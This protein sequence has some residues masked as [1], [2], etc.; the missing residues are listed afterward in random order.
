MYSGKSYRLSLKHP[1]RI[2]S[3]KVEV[4]KMSSEE[5]STSE[6]RGPVPQL[7]V[8][9]NKDQDSGDRSL[10][11]LEIPVPVNKKEC[12][13]PTL[14]VK[15]K[16]NTS[17]K[18][19]NKKKQK[20]TAS[21]CEPTNVQEIIVKLPRT[22]PDQI[23]TFRY[24]KLSKGLV[25]AGRVREINSSGLVISLPGRCQANV[26]I[27]K[28][29]TPYTKQLES[30]EDVAGLSDMFQ[31]GELVT[32][33]VETV[34][35]KNGK[36]NVSLSLNPCDANKTFKKSTLE[37]NVQL[38]GA[39]E[40]K[41]EHGYVIDVGIKNVSGFLPIKKVDPQALQGLVVGK[42]VR[43][44]VTHIKRLPSS[45]LI[46]TLSIKKD[47][48]YTALP[49][50][51]YSNTNFIPG[52]S[53]KIQVLEV[54]PEGLV[55]KP[56]KSNE[57]VTGHVNLNNL[58]NC[59]DTITRFKPS[60]VFYATL[61][62]TT[63]RDNKYFSL[64]PQIKN[65]NP[66]IIFHDGAL[67]KKAKVSSLAF[68]GTNFKLSSDEVNVRGVVPISRNGSKD[69]FEVG[70]MH[71]VRVMH[72]DFMEN[73]YI[74]SMKPDVLSIK[75]YTVN[76]LQVGQ[77]VEGKMIGEVAGKGVNLR[78][79]KVKVFVP[80]LHLTDFPNM[81]QKDNVLSP[82]CRMNN[83][84]EG[85][86]LCK[87]EDNI[88]VTLKPMLVNAAAL[89]NYF[90]VKVGDCYYGTVNS[91][92]DRGIVVDFYNHVTGFIPNDEI[93]PNILKRTFV[94]GQSIKCYVKEVD[95]VN[96]KLILTLK[97]SILN[98]G[99]YY[100]SRYLLTVIECNDKGFKVKVRDYE[101]IV[102]LVPFEHL[103]DHLSLIEPLKEYFKA[104]S[105]MKDAVA[106]SSNF[107][108]VPLFSLRKSVQAFFEIYGHDITTGNLHLHKDVI[109]PCSVTEINEDGIKVDVCIPNLRPHTILKKNIIGY[110]EHVLRS[111]SVDQSVL[112]FPSGD[113]GDLQLKL[114]KS[115]FYDTTEV[116]YGIDLFLDYFKLSN[117]LQSV[118]LGVRTEGTVLK[119]KKR[120][121]TV[122]LPSMNCEAIINKKFC[123]EN[124]KIGNFIDV[125]VLWQ[126]PVT[127]IVR[128]LPFE[129]TEL[130]PAHMKR[131]MLSPSTNLSSRRTRKRL[132]NRRI[133]YL[134]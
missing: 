6:S 15:R 68:D 1:C 89:C 100:G 41:E 116:G 118:P 86:V 40:S 113:Q 27:N 102:G 54:L 96:K 110:D 46:L 4:V 58:A 11:S 45:A 2:A 101:E 72:Y 30:G 42:L 129:P 53:I 107:E 8:E 39:I 98:K 123:N 133:Y 35:K 16:L 50:N 97:P 125:T 44:V 61:L 59:W 119:I 80:L 122:K 94:E 128:A 105:E 114:S 115:T 31:I 55:V 117:L 109:V 88:L 21:T 7:P 83:V 17:N 9:V 93:Q 43:G 92:D 75:V 74:C 26:D 13:R 22:V 52:T 132:V 32:A 71:T 65:V 78:V 63:P 121:V 108:S 64:W 106:Y 87:Q 5:A 99:Y 126:S 60:M 37:V 19:N 67:V 25:I 130:Q 124:L 76:D 70:E 104:G 79:G 34:N 134:R 73:V 103:T 24:K 3:W 120:S 36:F 81:S 77:V 66:D 91:K 29:S 20:R 131:L 49:R 85:K 82:I 48:F 47:I 84:V 111:L 57:D 18:K 90:D 112:V 69:D 28:I 95:P 14:L 127:K 38:I 10:G 23:T 12:K 33:T 56:V 51:G 62:Y